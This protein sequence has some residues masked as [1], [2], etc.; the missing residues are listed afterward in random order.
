VQPLAKLGS[1][2]C[3]QLRVL[4]GIEPSDHLWKTRL[5]NHSKKVQKIGTASAMGFSKNARFNRLQWTDWRGSV[6]LRAERTGARIAHF[7][8]ISQGGIE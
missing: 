3:R 6:S 2:P 5:K 1:L 4:F 7:T 8:K